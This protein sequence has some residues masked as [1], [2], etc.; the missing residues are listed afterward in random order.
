MEIPVGVACVDDSLTYVASRKK[1]LLVFLLSLGFVALGIWMSSEKPLLGWGG[2]AFFSL[3]IPVSFAMLLPGVTYLRLDREGFELGS[4]FRKHR[5]RWADVAGFGI[6][7][8]HSN[9]MVAVFYDRA[10]QGQKLGRAMSSSLTGIEGAIP[11]SYNASP[12]DIAAA[13]N[14]WKSRFG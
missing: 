8:I 9:K 6:C 1:A 4:L 5:T 12:D 10:Y 14:A 11:N 3:G 2:A 13:L 7:T